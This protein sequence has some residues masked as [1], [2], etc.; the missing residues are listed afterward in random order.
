M[1][2]TNAT[3][4]STGNLI[5][6]SIWNTDLVDNMDFLETQDFY[7]PTTVRY[8]GA[9]F[10]ALAASGNYPAAILSGA[11]QF[12]LTSFH[13]PANF[14]AIVTSVLIVIPTSTQASANWD[15]ES[16]YAA[17]GEAYNTHS[18]SDTVT[19][20]N[21]TAQQLFEVDVSGILSSLAA[22]DY[23]GLKLLQSTASHTVN[24]IGFYMKYTIG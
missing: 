23:V 14:S 15:I 18:E 20:Y 22:D 12:A 13:C 10:V 9:A 11:T 16:H 17:N 4:R 24:V 7:A 19:T 3:T 1:G 5:T 21:V 2:W 8:T 6:A